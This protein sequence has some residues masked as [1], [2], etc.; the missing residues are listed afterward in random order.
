MSEEEEEEVVDKE[1]RQACDVRAWPGGPKSRQQHPMM[2]APHEGASPTTLVLLGGGLWD[3]E[4]Q[5][6]W[7]ILKEKARLLMEMGADTSP[8]DCVINWDQGTSSPSGQ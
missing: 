3:R 8:W 7:R 4:K 6:K 5:S 2:D 1:E